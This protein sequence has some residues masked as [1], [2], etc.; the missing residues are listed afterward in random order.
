MSKPT[1]YLAGPITGLSYGEARHGW[2]DKVGRSLNAV[3][4]LPL[5]PMRGKEELNHVRRLSGDPDAYGDLLTTAQGILARDYN[6]V[7]RCDVVLANFLGAEQVSI[8][9]CC[10]FGFAYALRKPVVV[11]ME[12]EDRPAGFGRLPI[13]NPHRH[14]FLTQI[15]SYWVEDF[16]EAIF[17]VR[18][19][20]GHGV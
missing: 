11:I 20:V 13:S 2:R 3:G 18:H 4:I 17:A 10:E 19:L 9:T 14:A 1:C 12:K 7:A 8:G 16:E 5:S 15:A 6:D